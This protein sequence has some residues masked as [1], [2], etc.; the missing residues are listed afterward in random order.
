M[1][2]TTT[3]ARPGSSFAA[4]FASSAARTGTAVMTTASRPPTRAV[5]F[6]LVIANDPFDSI[7]GGGA[8]HGSRPAPAIH[9]RGFM[10]GTPAGV[11]SRG[12][13]DPR[14]GKGRL[15]S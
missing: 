12:Q 11:V 7:N 3:Y 13:P 4:S 6:A 2:T 8:V 9:V 5:N 14:R 10:T 1:P 15:A